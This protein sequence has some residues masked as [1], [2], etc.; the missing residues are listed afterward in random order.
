MKIINAMLVGLALCLSSLVAFAHHSTNGIYNEDKEVELT[1]T[2]VKWRFINPHPTL[3]VEVQGANGPETWDMSYGGS[4]VA[5]L[6]RRGYNADTF[7]AGDR[8]K[9]KGFVSKGEGTH[10]MLVRGNPVHED[11]SAILPEAPSGAGARP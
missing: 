8:I 2:V 4:A 7:K 11:G 3:S 1:G 5:H 6:V 9:V 10:G